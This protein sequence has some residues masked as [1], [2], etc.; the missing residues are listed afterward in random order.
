[1]SA[2]LFTREFFQLTRERLAPGGV[3]VQWVPLYALSATHFEALLAT[4]LDV[5]P[6]VSIFHV[7]EG[8]LIAIAGDTPLSVEPAGVSGFFLEGLEDDLLG[9][10]IRGPA[11]LLA[12]WVADN[13]GLRQ[14]VG[15]GLL[16]T[17]DNGLL[18]FGSPW[19]ILSDTR[20][21]NLSL[22]EKAATSSTI[23]ERIGAAML[24]RAGGVALAK[25][26]AGHYLANQRFD[27]IRALA[28]AFRRHGHLADADLLEGDAA[29]AQGRWGEADKIWS[30][31]QGPAFRLRRARLAF[32][33]GR[34]RQAAQLFGAVPRGERS[35]DDNVLFA[36]ALA[37]TGRAHEAL[38]VLDSISATTPS[39]AGIM[40]PFM[41]FI[42]LNE[43]G[44]DEAEL[45]AR[46]GFEAQL[47][48]LR[49]CME[50]D[51]CGRV[52]ET[53]LRRAETMS[54]E[55]LQDSSETLRQSL[56]VRVTRPLPL[57]FRGVNQLWLGD[58][59]A[60]RTSLQTYLKLLPEP[61]P[62]S[63]AHSILG[64]IQSGPAT[65]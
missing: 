29:G 51:R 20:P 1:M 62:L 22:I 60:A 8:D 14:V 63:N 25:D 36:S 54:S 34:L 3:L 38:S 26:L 15:R 49:R 13:D 31:Q 21:A 6:E 61:D 23:L 57:Y 53:I 9:I 27:S 18:E 4:L 24:P 44:R 11:D 43:L 40:A 55:V 32:K 37:G 7:A 58:K 5:F 56:F 59:V 65:R 52:A 35:T 45:S 2:R 48:G 64:S 17:D 16:N 30:R 47:D 46:R 41:R 28:D 10:G 12:R 33:M 42:L 39:V 50:L 19:Y